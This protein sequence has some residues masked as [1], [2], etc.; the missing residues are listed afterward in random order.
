VE[1]RGML[2]SGRGTTICG[3]PADPPAIV[4]AVT[5]R[6]AVVVAWEDEEALARAILGV[7]AE[8]TVV[9][10]VEAAAALAAIA[11]S[12]SGEGATLFVLPPEASSRLTPPAHGVRLL[13]PEDRHHLEALP[14]R[15]RGEIANRFEATAMAAAFVE[16]RPVSFCYAGWETE[17][18]WDV[19]ID[20][21]DAWRRRGLAA[22]AATLLIHHHSVRGRRPVWGAVDS[23]VASNTLAR[24]LGFEPIDRLILLYP[25]DAHT[26]G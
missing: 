16:D 24:K 8:F 12:R 14:P 21:L 11:P 19:S 15:L 10:P 7:P 23:N 25:D 4:A 22:A 5:D 2:L 26:H 20:T 3:R 6:L 13:G 9:A 18:L 1:A 17:T